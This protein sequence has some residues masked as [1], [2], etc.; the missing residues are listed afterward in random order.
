MAIVRPT[1][2]TDHRLDIESS[3]IRVN[4]PVSRGLADPPVNRPVRIDTW[5]GGELSSN[6]VN[7][8]TRYRVDGSGMVECPL[9]DYSGTVR[10]VK[11]HIS[12]KA[13]PAHQGFTGRDFTG[14]FENDGKTSGGSRAVTP[15]KGKNGSNGAGNGGSN[16]NKSNS[17]NGKNT[18]TGNGLPKVQCKKCGREVKYPELMPYK[19]TCPECGRGLREREAFEELEKK[20]DE[21]GNDELAEPVEV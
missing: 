10:E 2:A 7:G 19:A 4:R 14:Y 21:R 16:G 6:L 5:R 12:G 11:G 17:S 1:V 18:A 15:E 20:A 8:F 13:D 9:C 3:R